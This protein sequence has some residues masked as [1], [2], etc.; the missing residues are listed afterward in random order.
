MAYSLLSSRSLRLLVDD[1]DRLAEQRAVA[2]PRRAHAGS[3]HLRAD[4]LRRLRAERQ[5]ALHAVEAGTLAGRRSR[6]GDRR[7]HG[8]HAVVG[9]VLGPAGAVPVAQLVAGERIGVP[10]GRDG[11][12][13][14]GRGSRIAHGCE[15]TRAPCQPRRWTSGAQRC[16]WQALDVVTDDPPPG[17][18]FRFEDVVVRA[19]APPPKRGEERGAPITILAGIDL[20]IGRGQLT[21]LAGPSG[22]GKS[23]LLRLCNRLEVPTSGRVLLD[24]RDIVDLDPLKLRRRAR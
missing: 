21:V 7:V 15:L 19:D 10:A 3:G 11:G 13:W 6:A 8:R 1:Q 23:T 14:W 17:S 2:R 24:D 5:R 22:S 20:V 18:G 9:H 12:R 4:L 16:P